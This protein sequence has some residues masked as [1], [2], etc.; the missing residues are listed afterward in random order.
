MSTVLGER[1]LARSDAAAWLP[2]VA[3]LAGLGALYVPTYADLARG[4]WREDAYAHGPIVL[5]VFAWL[6]WRGRAALLD[7]GSRPAPWS[8]AALLAA[9]LALYLLGRTQSLAVF[10]V[11]S[12]LPVIAGA[13]L[14]VRGWKALRRLAFPVAFLAFAVPLPGFVL[15]FATVPLKGLVSASVET[16]LGA[17]AY[18]VA[19]EGVVLW[20]GD[21]AMLVAD[22]CSGLN[23]LYSLFALGLLYSQVV[24]RR[25]IARTLLLVAAMVPIAVAA[26]IV[27]VVILVLVTYHWGEEAATG[28]VHDATGMLVF[29]VAFALLLGFDRI[30][31]AALDRQEARRP[32][33]VEFAT[34]TSP[35][36]ARAAPS[37]LRRAGIAGLAA[38]LAMA[39][40]AVAAP[41]LKPRPD[42]APAPDLEKAIPAA[43]A[44]WRID[45][46]V[47]QVA[48]APDVQANLDRL[49]RQIVTRTYVNDAGEQMMLTV[50]HGGDQSDALKAHRQEACYAAQG[51]DIRSLAHGRLAV[52]GRDIPV[53]RMLAVRADRAEPVTYWFTMGDRVVLG[54]A[55]RLRVQLEHGFAGRIPDGM[56]VRVSSLS[57]DAPR[58]FAAQ[59][60][61]MAALIGALAP[62]DAVRF[63]GRS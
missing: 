35:R 38:A 36:L 31:R 62:A 45:P 52:A 28:W 46:D 50:A 27:R 54:R 3:V 14:L 58:A 1:P 4:L 17:L 60:A 41:L 16:L 25:A 47:V 63:A 9:G 51:F 34:S 30:V 39:G 20:V 37:R 15:D 22:A 7:E 24:G 49:Y 29:V 6:A 12:H 42:G 33:E 26:N 53:T 13:I 44:G 61:F 10:E 11:A 56:L 21:H 59:Q 5:A 40:A 18:P 23:S 19:R 43:F 2:W 32:S 55:E 57:A 48:P 8:G